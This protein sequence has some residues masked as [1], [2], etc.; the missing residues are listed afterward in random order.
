MLGKQARHAVIHHR[1]HKHSA[2]VSD[3]LIFMKLVQSFFDRAALP[4]ACLSCAPP[5]SASGIGW[6]MPGDVMSGPRVK[7][8]RV[9]LWI[10]PYATLR[11]FGE[12][13]ITTGAGGLCTP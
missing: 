5:G 8:S 13:L 3:R 6:A 12:S 1:G 9:V 4:W 10:L 7:L 11:Q 2:Q